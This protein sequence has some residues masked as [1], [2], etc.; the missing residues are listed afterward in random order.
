MGQSSVKYCTAIIKAI[1][2]IYI[3]ISILEGILKGSFELAYVKPD[4]ENPEHDVN[5]T[6]CSLCS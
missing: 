1:E 5:N 3:H 2:R 4:N 6:L